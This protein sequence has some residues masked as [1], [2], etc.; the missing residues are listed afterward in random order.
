MLV[1]LS[2][3]DLAFRDEVR[4]FLAERLTTELREVG[5]RMTSVFVDRD[6]NL[7]WQ[8]ILN[9][10]GW[11]AP[12]WP[13]EY[14]GPG[15][16]ETQ[17]WI[18]AGECAAASAPGL[19]PQGLKMVAPVLMRY[20]TEEQKRHYLPRILSGEDYW[21]QG[22]S[23][24][25]A[26]SDLASL[27]MSAIGD[28]DDYVLDG[29]KIW[30][31]H[32]HFANRIFCLVRTSTTGKPQAGITFLLIDMASPGITV[33]PIISLSGDHELNQVFFDNVRVPK[34]NRVG[35]ENDGWTVAKVLLEFERGGRASSGLKVGIQRVED[36]ARAEGLMD[37][38]HYR[39]RVAELKVAI[40]A[41]EMTEQRILSAFV[42]GGN[43]GSLSSL[44]KIQAT[45]AM[46]KVDELAVEVAG[47]YGAV[48]QTAARQAL[49]QMAYVGPE[50]ALTAVPRYYNNRA[51]SIYGGSNE[52]QRNLIAKLLLGL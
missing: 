46:Q 29:S 31:T 47:L 28:G 48:E 12:D 24:P 27:R 13:T 41:I 19:A 35:A 51:A 21:C 7:A 36:Q 44:L 20:G 4:A 38:P 9:E 26:G 5:R 1:Q 3:E 34:A 33:R 39:Q 49:S 15:W 2:P 11:A 22:Y 52:I 40:A 37:E 23:E 14:G 10:K 6:Y 17:R 45:E 43:P 16:S 25:G 18:F 30:T 42:G 50:S 32:A 8:A